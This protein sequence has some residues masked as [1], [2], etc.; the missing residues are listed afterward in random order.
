MPRPILIISLW[1]FNLVFEP[2]V[3]RYWPPA[4][5][6]FYFFWLALIAFVFL[7]PLDR[8]LSRKK[9]AKRAGGQCVD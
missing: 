5:I 8:Y 3:H 1:N 4:L 6:D 7:G 9:K 2:H